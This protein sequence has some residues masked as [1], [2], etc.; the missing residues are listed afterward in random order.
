MISTDGSMREEVAH[1][2][3]QIRKVCGMMAQLGKV[4]M[5][6]REVIRELRKSCDTSRHI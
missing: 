2:V 6:Y 3:P 4:N 5:V 1:I